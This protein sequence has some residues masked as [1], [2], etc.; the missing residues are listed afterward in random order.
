[1]KYT[2][3][4]PIWMWY[5]ETYP[6]DELGREIKTTATFYGLFDALENYQDV[7]EYLGVNDSVVRE[8]CFQKLAHLIGERYDYI[9]DQWLL[10]A[11]RR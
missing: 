2:I 9:Y 7:Y 3:H 1:M 10:A 4:A 6:S 5:R 8:R 11:D